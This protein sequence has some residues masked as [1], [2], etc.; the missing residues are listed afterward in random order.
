MLIVLSCLALAIGVVGWIN[1]KHVSEIRAEKKAESIIQQA[2]A[3]H[4]PKNAD[5]KIIALTKEV[6]ETFEHTN[7]SHVPLLKLR[8]YITNHRLPEIIRLQTG[9]IETHVQKG[10]CDNASR[11]LAFLLEKEGMHSTQWNMVTNRSGQ[12]S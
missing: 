8:P 12:P 3:K 10:L 2:Y 7:P 5:E 6:F 1:I 4:D 9:V 11:M